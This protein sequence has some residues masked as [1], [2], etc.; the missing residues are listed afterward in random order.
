MQMILQ[1]LEHL[2]TD[3]H[4]GSNTVNKLDLING[5]KRPNGD[6]TFNRR[7]VFKEFNYRFES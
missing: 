1:L 4:H 2:G 3:L 6:I 5:P 7:K